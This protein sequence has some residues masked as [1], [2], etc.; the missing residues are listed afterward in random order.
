MQRMPEYIQDLVSQYGI[1]NVT[2][3]TKAAAG[4]VG[5][6]VGTSTGIEPFFSWTYFRKSR[7]GVNKEHIKVA[8]DWLGQHEGEKLPDYFATAM[9]LTP[10]EHVRVQ[11]AVQRWTDSAISKTSNAPQDYTLEQT[12]QLHTLMYN[13]GCKGGTIYRDGSRDEQILATDHKKLGKDVAEQIEAKQ[14]ASLSPSTLL[15]TS[16]A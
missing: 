5:T 2:I 16:A 1:R 8:Q 3:L 7:L 6:M 11:A 14:A 9:E 12:K 15:G 10:E 4:P 13:L